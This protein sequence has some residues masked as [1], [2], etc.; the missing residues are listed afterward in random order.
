M[1]VEPSEISAEIKDIARKL[2]FSA[3]GVAHV[4]PFKKEAEILK[5]YLGKNFHGSMKFLEDHTDKRTYP[6]KLLPG[7]QSV[8]VLAAA[9]YHASELRAGKYKIARYAAGRDYHKVLK[10]HMKPLV[11]Y[12]TTVGGA[13]FARMYCDS[14]PVFEK[15]FAVRAGL[16]FQ[17][18][19]ST[20]II[21]EA[22]SFFF[23]AEIY[24]DAVLSF[25]APYE[26]NQ[27]GKCTKCIDA[28]P[29]NAIYPQGGIN[30]AKCISYLSIE[31]KQTPL[32]Y[33]FDPQA[34]IYGCDICQEACPHN[35]SRNLPVFD[36]FL[37]AKPLWELTEEKLKSMDDTQFQ[38]MFANSS[39]KRIGLERFI[40]NIRAAD[41]W[42]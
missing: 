36:E 14:A 6:E 19:N 32:H 7:T 17:G 41:E 12:L 25:D 3:C 23:L 9:Y 2:G 24:T 28:C 16:G 20:L 29:S 37:P 13:T 22:G 38:W 30:A 35:K 10:K 33:S 15:A 34:W 40:R 4:A 42:L 18:K 1:S 21:P 11:N 26:M 31:N 8:I 27:C 39:I 5:N